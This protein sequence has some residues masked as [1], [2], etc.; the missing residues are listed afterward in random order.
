MMA[1]RS[2]AVTS[3]SVGTAQ[4]ALGGGR[5]S[6]WR[7]LPFL[8][9]A[10]VASVAYIDPGNFATNIAGGAKF[11]FTLCWVIVAANLMAML[12]QTLSA[13]LGIATGRNLPEV[14]RERF[15]RRTSMGL[16]IQ[17]ELIAMATDLA[18]F[19]GAALGFHLL[20]GIALFPAALLTGVATFAILGLQRFGLRTF[21]AVIIAFIATIGA[22]YLA[23]LW[24][25]HPPL[26][27]V[28]LH[29]VKPQFA[30][31]ESVLLAVGILGAT[32]MPHVIY[33][34][35]ALTA[36]RVVPSNDAE[37]KRLYRYT[38]IDVVIAMSIAGLINMA[39]LVVA[40]T[41]FYGSGLPHIESLE[42]AWRT[43]TPV[44]GGAASTLFA[45]ALLA[46]GLSSSTVGTLS[47]QVVM[48]GFID[49]QIPVFVRRLVTMLPALVVAAIGVDPSRTLVISQVVL[50]FGIPFALI[51]LVWFTSR[52]NVMGTLVNR[53]VTTGIASA[54]A[55]G[56]TALNVFLLTQ[57]FGLA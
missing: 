43:L 54:V 50:S 41:V 9:P 47:G 11:G 18:E 38:K 48:Q 24:F 14:C 52:P 5:V 4:R 8:G 55:A 7:V 21:E 2:D 36:N 40:A 12:I 10:F 6:G 29:A 20:F 37:A 32:V 42:G 34:H 25:A 46:S 17:A 53:K 56:I 3:G 51:P 35:S 22:C 39:M 13:K 57:T 15:S 28:A 27:T 16:W 45:L 33:L 30:G 1:T 23:E 31:S 26:G 49:R 44:L 19:L